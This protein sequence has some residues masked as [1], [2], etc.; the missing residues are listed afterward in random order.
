MTCCLLNGRYR[1]IFVTQRQ[2]DAVLQTKQIHEIISGI[3]HNLQEH[4]IVLC[5]VG[6]LKDTPGVKITCVRGK[7][8]LPH[9]V[10]RQ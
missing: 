7:Y 3:G 9:V 5:K 10:K 8:D 2:L 6:K 4:N 1:R